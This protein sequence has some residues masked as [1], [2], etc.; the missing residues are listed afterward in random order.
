MDINDIYKSIRPLKN[1]IHLS[2]A[3]LCL[4][5]GL[6]AAGA[7][8]LALALSAFFLPVPF[9]LRDISVICAASIAASL[10]VSVFFRPGNLKAM[11][12]ADSLGLKER[13]VTAYELRD[14]LEPISRIQRYD[15]LKALS[16]ANPASKYAIRF[17]RYQALA[18]LV[19]IAV[20]ALT[21]SIP[22]PSK[23]KAAVM[24]N[25]LSEVKKQAEKIDQERKE[26]GKKANLSEKKLQEVNRK[27]DTLLAE[28]KKSDS[29]AKAVK[30]LA[31]TKHELEEL[32]N[33]GLNDDLK[34][35]AGRME[36]NPLTRDFGQALKQGDMAEMKKRLEGLNEKLKGMDANSRKELA[37]QFKKAAAEVAKSGELARNLA[38]LS[39]EISSGNLDALQSRMAELGNTLSQLAQSDSALASAMQQFENEMLQQLADSLDDS[40]QQ[41]SDQAGNSARTAQGS[42]QGEGNQPGGDGKGNQSGQDEDGKS[43]R[44]GSGAGNQSSGGDLGYSGEESGSGARQ[45]GQKQ[46]R[47][48]EDVYVPSRLG[49]DSASSQVKGAKTAS[50]QSQWA[51]SGSMP[52]EKGDTLP[53]DQVL[54]EYRSQAMQGL[55]DNPIPPVM[56]DIVRD[57]FTSLE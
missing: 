37:E 35:L 21:L 29:E 56:K 13:L 41:I 39:R 38:A 28:L 4:S 52:V 46:M 8:S 45:P 53:Y 22:S 7:A 19:L 42:S 25:V 1:R 24:E 16:K 18:S 36:E 49:G 32:K 30:A 40:R 51:E 20:T 54:G 14:S 27:I 31:K 55:D 15:A 48:Y 3:V 6:T 26:L 43:K 44:G 47:E 17:P 33:K 57:Y 11:K 9:I 23:E 10:V 12:V 50:G 2:K 5:W 34:T